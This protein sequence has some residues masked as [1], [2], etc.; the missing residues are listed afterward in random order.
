MNLIACMTK[1]RALG[2]DGKLLFHLS[3]DLKFFKNM[4]EGKVV[5]MGKKTY[6][7]LPVRPLKNRVNIVLT[8]DK[9]FAEQGVIVVNDLKML[10]EELK[11]Y[12]SHDVFVCG[13]ESIY[14]QLKDY[15]DTAYITNVDIVSDADT[16]MFDLESN[17]FTKQTASAPQTE[18]GLNFVFETYKKQNLK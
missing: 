12:N 2:K 16:Y 9:N 15:C 13:G 11:K 17:G 1:N 6:L 3:Q 18:N 8:K 14:N 7:S 4:T 5:V 10:F